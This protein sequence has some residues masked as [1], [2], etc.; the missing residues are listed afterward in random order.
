MISKF[1][2]MQHDV[3]MN[4]SVFH[5]PSHLY[6]FTPKTLRTLLMQAGFDGVRIANAIPVENPGMPIKTIL[7]RLVYYS[8][9]AVTKI[10][11]GVL[12]LS[13]SMISVAIKPG[14]QKAIAEHRG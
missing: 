12:V 14:T 9:S 2:K 1:H 5:V 8:T 6:L 13:Y 11:A 10:S 3:R 4:I 7:K